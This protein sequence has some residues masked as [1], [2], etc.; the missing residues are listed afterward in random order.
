M[1][2]ASGGVIAA[3]DYNTLVTSLNAVWNT[4][5][6]QTALS[7]VATG[8]TVTAA[9]WSTLIG[10]LNKTLAHQSGTA[11]ISLP[12]AGNVITYLAAVNSGVTTANTNQYLASTNGTIVTGS[13]FIATPSN[14]NTTT[15]YNSTIATRTVTF[16]SA[17]QAAYFFNSGGMLTFNIPSVTG[18]GTSAANDLVTLLGTNLNGVYNFARTGNGGR[19]GSGGTLTSQNVALGFTTATTALQNIAN[20]A[21]TT[22]LYTTDTAQIQVSVN[23]AVVT[24]ALVL[25]QGA[26][27]Y[28][29]SWS[30]SVTTRVNIV[31]PETTN[32][33]NSWGTITIA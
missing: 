9:Q 20:V 10:T 28:A 24:F 5:Y 31:P 15:A 23:G 18:S 6:G 30:L 27:T 32:L 12:T 4:A 7:T 2:Y 25:N 16:P 11:A 19:T 13:N 29:S 26:H 22:A 8:N 17:A 33:A 14:A 3:S 1:S 21:S